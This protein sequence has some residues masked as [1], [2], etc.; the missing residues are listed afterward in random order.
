MLIGLSLLFVGGFVGGLLREVRVWD[1]WLLDMV[2]PY[3]WWML[4]LILWL[5]QMVADVTVGTLAGVYSVL[6]G[7]ALAILGAFMKTEETPEDQFGHA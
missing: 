3:Q 4:P 2:Y 5:A 6:A 7:V 1:F